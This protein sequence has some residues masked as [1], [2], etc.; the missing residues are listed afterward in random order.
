MGE[1][2]HKMAP[3]P[4]RWKIYVFG[5]RGGNATIEKFFIVV[6]GVGGVVRHNAAHLNALRNASSLRNIVKHNTIHKIH[7]SNK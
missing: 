4:F 2:V 3:Q 6:A 1:K 7:N 5:I